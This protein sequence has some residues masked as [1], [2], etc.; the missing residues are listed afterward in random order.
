VCVGVQADACDGENVSDE[1][2]ACPDGRGAADLPKH[3]RTVASGLA[4]D[5]NRRGARLADSGYD[6]APQP[7]NPGSRA[8][9]IEGSVQ[10][11]GRCEAID[12]G[13][14]G[15]S[16]QLRSTREGYRIA[17]RQCCEGKVRKLGIHVGLKR[18]GIT[19]V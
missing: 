16:S 6:R 19:S 2:S 15:H 13:A 7:E 3:V 9:E 1:V 5:E 14:E 17:A 12:P 11:S 4:I 18:D 8:R 10:E